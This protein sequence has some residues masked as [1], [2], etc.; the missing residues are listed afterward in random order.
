[1]TPHG[2]RITTR[3]YLQT[4]LFCFTA[5]SNKLKEASALSHTNPQA[6]RIYYVLT[7]DVMSVRVG[8]LER[9]EQS[10]VPQ[11]WSWALVQNTASECSGGQGKTTR[12]LLQRLH[13]HPH[14]CT[15]KQTSWSEILSPLTHRSDIEK[16][17]ALMIVP[18][19]SHHYKRNL[20]QNT[21]IPF[22]FGELLFIFYSFLF[23]CLI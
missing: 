14:K 12:A 18:F 1:M 4:T 16:H 3:D 20:N 15:C 9:L 13:L 22:N 8:A 7:A 17:Y 21:H 19:F 23:Y 6:H 11:A 10:G 5:T 2:F